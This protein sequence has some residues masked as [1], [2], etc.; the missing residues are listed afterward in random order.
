MFIEK[1]IKQQVVITVGTPE[2]KII[3][4]SKCYS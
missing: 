4:F 1:E 2:E 3:A